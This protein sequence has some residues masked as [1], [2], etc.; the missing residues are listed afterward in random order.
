M[1]FL[2]IIKQAPVGD[3]EWKQ[4]MAEAIF[5]RS[6]TENGPI[7]NVFLSNPWMLGHVSVIS[8]KTTIYI[9][10]IIAGLGEKEKK[11]GA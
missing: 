3:W 2:L 1:S 7:Q 10:I 5:V 4:T 11:D 6:N 8:T 9:L